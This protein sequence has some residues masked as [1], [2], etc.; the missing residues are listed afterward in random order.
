[1]L[2]D[3]VVP[4]IVLEVEQVPDIVLEVE[5]VLLLVHELV[6]LEVV[7]EADSFEHPYRLVLLEAIEQSLYRTRRHSSQSLMNLLCYN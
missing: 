1:M 6:V 5:Q 4:D 3:L 2:R 7:L